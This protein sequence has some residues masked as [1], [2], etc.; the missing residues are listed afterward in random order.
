LN[1]YFFIFY[2]IIKTKK[3]VKKITY[4]CIRIE[5]RECSKDA[6]FGALMCRRCSVDTNIKIGIGSSDNDYLNE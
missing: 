1:N 4:K 2:D 6:I 5:G 3:D